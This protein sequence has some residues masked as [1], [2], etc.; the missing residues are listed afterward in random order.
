MTKNKKSK[1]NVKKNIENIDIEES[2][3]KLDKIITK[4]ENDKCSLKDSIELYKE[5]LDYIN[6]T[7]NSLD[8]IKHELEILDE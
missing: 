6:L 8:S 3:K 4:L 5:G 2:F 7:K 1:V